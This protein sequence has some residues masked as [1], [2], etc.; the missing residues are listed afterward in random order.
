MRIF[1][2]LQA[3]FTPES[4]SSMQ[5]MCMWNTA[6]I[7]TAEE[8]E[9]GDAVCCWTGITCKDGHVAS[10]LWIHAYSFRVKSVQWFPLHLSSVFISGQNE[11]KEF[12]ARHLPR[13]LIECRLTECNLTGT[14]AVSELP[15][16]LQVINLCV[17]CFKGPISLTGIRPQLAMLDIRFCAIQKVVVDNDALSPDFFGAMFSKYA[18]APSVKVIEAQGRKPDE[19]IQ[20][21]PGNF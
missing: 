18:G 11:P 9:N 21:M 13:S 16:N 8:A 4:T 14:V 2:L 7:L 12:S 6:D 17:N 3:D 1:L 10:I 19:R 15:Q 5:R 20:I